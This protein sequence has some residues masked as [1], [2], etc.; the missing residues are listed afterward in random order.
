MSDFNK[1][2][3]QLQNWTVKTDL[4]SL[5][6]QLLF[7]KIGSTFASFNGTSTTKPSLIDHIFLQTHKD[8]QLTSTGGTMHPQLSDL[9]D[10]N[11]LWEGLQWPETLPPLKK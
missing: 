1:S 7:S 2:L 11:V 10:H 4:G 6:E 8:F 9:T 3:H 5:G